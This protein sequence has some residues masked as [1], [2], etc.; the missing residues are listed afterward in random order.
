MNYGRIDASSIRLSA[1]KWVFAL[2]KK[3]NW[4]KVRENPPCI[5]E[6]EGRYFIHCIQKNV[7]WSGKRLKKFDTCNYYLETL[8][9]DNYGQIYRIK[10]M[11][12]CCDDEG[13]Y[14]FELK[15][16]TETFTTPL[17]PSQIRAVK[18]LVSEDE[19][20]FAEI[21]ETLPRVKE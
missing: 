16:D 14:W 17:L 5:T 15:A 6:P 12:N 10:S 9:I 3:L 19:P 18:S 20:G 13:V 4:K 21:A 8:L 11:K 7:F 1:K 2:P